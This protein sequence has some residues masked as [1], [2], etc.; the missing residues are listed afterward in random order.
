[1]RYKQE[2]L[3]LSTVVPYLKNENLKVLNIND[4]AYKGMYLDK[5]FIN[6]NCCCCDGLRFC[7][8]DI[9]YPPIVA[10]NIINPHNKKYRCIDGKHRIYKLK[11]L[12]YKQATFFVISKEIFY[13]CLN[14]S[15]SL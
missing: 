15:I 8:A 9:T 5:K 14:H 13:K 1:M 10:D 6:E 2:Q 4:V 12:G 3:H 7:H 11:K